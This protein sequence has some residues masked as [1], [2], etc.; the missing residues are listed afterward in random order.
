MEAELD[1]CTYGLALAQRCVMR[2]VWYGAC[3]FNFQFVPVRMDSQISASQYKIRV[4]QHKLGGIDLRC[5]NK[6][7]HFLLGWM[8]VNMGSTY[9]FQLILWWTLLQLPRNTVV[10]VEEKCFDGVLT[11]QLVVLCYIATAWTR[12]LTCTEHMRDKYITRSGE[13]ILLIVDHEQNTYNSFV[14]VVIP[15]LLLSLQGLQGLD[16]LIVHEP[17][18]V[19]LIATMP[20]VTRV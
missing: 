6:G 5:W 17:Q 12:E 9:C 1:Y 7:Y 19:R 15:E 16:L 13:D 3:L 11:D 8:D 14:L 18:G 2:R 20:V 10:N 4:V